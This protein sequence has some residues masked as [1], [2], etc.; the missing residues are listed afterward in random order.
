MT[1]QVPTDLDLMEMQIEALF[2]H[3]AA[4]RIVR[5]AGVTFT[6]LGRGDTMMSEGH[7]VGATMDAPVPEIRT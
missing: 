5:R 4:G 3:G 6:R 7:D 1:R 2:T